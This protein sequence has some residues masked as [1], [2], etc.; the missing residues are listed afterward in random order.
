MGYRALELVIQS[1]Q[2]L[3][4]VHNAP[5]L[6]K[7]N[8]FALVSIRDN[9]NNLHSSE[10]QTP[11]DSEGNTNPKWN[12]HVT[13]NIDITKVKEN[14]LALVVKIKSRRI[15]GNRDVGEVRVLITELEGFG[16]AKA[17]AERHVSKN[18][19]N[20]DGTSQQGEGT[21]NFSY[22]FG[23]TVQHPPASTVNIGNSATP[24]VQRRPGTA[25]RLVGKFKDELGAVLT[26]FNPFGAK[27]SAADPYVVDPS[28]AES[29][30][31]D[32][33]DVEPYGIEP[34]GTEPYGTEPS[35]AD[36]SVVDPSGARSSAADP[37]VVDPSGAESSAVDRSDVEPYC[38]EPYGTE[39]SAADT[40]GGDYGH[41]NDDDADY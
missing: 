27:S 11:I 36:P 20:L 38:T 8:P 29:S 28:G 39:P 33:S 25:R 37:S 12:F 26:N 23:N 2:G 10:E 7:M 13:F 17:V 14:H 32:R 16:D 4:N 3:R 9:S 30:A 5:Q 15:T 19:V 1:A 40:Y 34:Y 6:R 35:A 31:A 22:K 21:L 41:A 24:N 18:V